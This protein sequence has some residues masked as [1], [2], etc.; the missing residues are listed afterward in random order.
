VSANRFKR[1]GVRN[2]LNARKHSRQKLF[3]LNF[4]LMENPLAKEYNIRWSRDTLN[5][6]SRS[7]EDTSSTMTIC[8]SLSAKYHEVFLPPVSKDY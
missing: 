6:A 8:I 1:K 2:F 3:L 7:S 4:L 5:N